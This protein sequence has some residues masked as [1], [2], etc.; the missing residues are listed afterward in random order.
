MH[1]LMGILWLVVVVGVISLYVIAPYF[2]YVAARWYKVTRR[3]GKGTAD[4]SDPQ[5][6]W[7]TENSKRIRSIMALVAVASMTVYVNQRVKWMGEDNANL[8][9][10][11]YYVSGQVLNAFRAMLTTFIH[12]EIPILAPLHWLQAAI[13]NQG[14]QQLPE[15]DGEK[16]VWQ[17]Q[18]FHY[19]YSK[20]DREELFIVNW[21]P[22]ETMRA[23]L[24]QWW[25]SLESMATGSYADRQMEEEHYYFDFTSLAMSYRL[26]KGYYA[27]HYAGSEHKLALMPNHVERARLLS[28]WLWELQSKWRLS[29]KIMDFIEKNPRLEAMY[30]YVLQYELGHYLQGTIN[31]HQFSCDNIA[32]ERYVAARKQFVDPD[33]GIAAYKRMQNSEEAKRLYKL[34]VDKGSSVRYVL[35]NYCRIEVAGKEDNSRYAEWAAI[36]KVTVDQEAEERAKANFQDEIKILEEQFK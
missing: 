36:H 28:E 21:R 9:A 27:S 31:Q 20:K 35:H 22:T 7:T 2:I 15:K 24:D 11:E 33:N 3:A 16:G 18:W 10:K 6:F 17:N 12:P 19:H 23:R 14:I 8:T 5:P 25:N 13:Y 1:I 30:L 26:C 4:F 34:S 29:S 32:I